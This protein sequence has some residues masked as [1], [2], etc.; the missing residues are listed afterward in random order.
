MGEETVVVMW[1]RVLK[2]MINIDFFPKTKKDM[3]VNVIKDRAKN[4][5]RGLSLQCEVLNWRTLELI[6]KEKNWYT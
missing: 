2:Q 3:S 1:H 4:R 5:S 6:R